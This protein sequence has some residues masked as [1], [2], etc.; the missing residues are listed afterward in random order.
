MTINIIKEKPLV[1]VVVPTWNRCDDLMECLQSIQQLTYPN[2]KV[3]IIDNGSID[4]TVIM[5]Q[6]QFP[7]MHLIQLDGNKGASVASNAG[8]TFAYT[9]N[10]DYFLRVDSD[11]VLSPDMLTEF[12]LSAQRNPDTGLFGAKVFYYDTPDILWSI[13]AFRHHWHLGALEISSEKE[14][15]DDFNSEIV[16]DYVWSAGILI[17]RQAY[18]ATRGFD[19]DYFVYYEDVDFC[20]RIQALGLQIRYVP[21]AVMQHKVG[22]ENPTAARAYQWGRGKMLFIRKWSSGVHRISLII[23]AYSYALYRAVRPKAHAGNR[24]PLLPALRGLTTGLTQS[25]TIFST[26]QAKNEDLD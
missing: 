5:V 16:V 2:V 14:D 26:S 13:G 10:A 15:S 21:T 12:I 23:Y 7:A 11:T 17:S 6:E 20:L 9:H 4:R 19:P 3:V 18:E 24:G 25:I 22:E 1:W 8:L